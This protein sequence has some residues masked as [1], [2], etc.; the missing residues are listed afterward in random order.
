MEQGIR[1]TAQCDQPR[2]GGGPAE[3]PRATTGDLDRALASTQKGFEAWRS[4]SA[5]TRCDIVM[6]G[7]RILRERAA[8]IA[9]QITMEQGKPVG[10]AKLEIIRAASIIE[11]DVNEGRRAYGTI[12]PSDP[13][14]ARYGLRL[15]IGPVAAFTPWNFPISSPARKIGGA[16]AAGCSIVV[17]GSRRRPPRSQ[18][19]WNA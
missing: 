3:L 15:P 2:D 1:R 19:W 12:V 11:W 14:F 7:C 18:H 17:K 10:E 8:E 4:L 13:G 9:P 6:K 5:E 16:L